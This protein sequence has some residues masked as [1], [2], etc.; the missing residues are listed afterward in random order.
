MAK[1]EP[2]KDLKDVTS[3][4]TGAT[5]SSNAKTLFLDPAAADRAA[6][7]CRTM[8]GQLDA[9]IQKEH[10]LR[11]DG[12]LNG[13]LSSERLGKDRLDKKV[14]GEAGSFIHAINEHKEALEKMETAIRAA[15]KAYEGT[16][17]A[18]RN[19]FKAL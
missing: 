19:S 13:F 2:V 17:E 3:T 18:T 11:T 14:N 1:P 16:D 15:R 12:T 7:A 6:N 5:E 8:R 9:L 4:F 10:E